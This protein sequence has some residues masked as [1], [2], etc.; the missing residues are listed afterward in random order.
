MKKLNINFPELPYA[1]EQSLKRLQ[2]NVA[3]SG[4][5]TKKILITSSV[6]NEGKSF[7]SIQLWKM[8]AE[9]GSRAVFVDLDFRNSELVTRHSIACE[10]KSEP[11]GLDFYLSGR[12]E[13][14]DV[15]YSTNVDNGDFVPCTNLLENPS[16][17]FEDRRFEELL[18]R[19]AEDYRYVIIDS[20][21]LEYV[22]DGN[23]IATHCDG[24][25]LVVRCAHVPRK[26]IRNS[27]QTLEAV[28]C[29]LLGVALNREDKNSRG[30]GKYYGGYGYGGYGE[31]S[32]DKKSKR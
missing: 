3:F 17:L 25:I 8:L 12:A 14:E 15:V 26:I 19:L 27:M 16:S 28:G 10:D 13:L 22:A 1:V 9:S 20:A 7:I 29:K 31:Y 11:V 32:S 5:D 30:Y 21:P 24:A 6:P 4:N 2:I 18:D 23:L